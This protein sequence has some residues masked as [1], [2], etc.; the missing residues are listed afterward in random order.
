MEILTLGFMMLS[1]L[2]VFTADT[3]QKR[4]EY[5]NEGKAE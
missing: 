4:R 5:L 1:L 2:A 3:I